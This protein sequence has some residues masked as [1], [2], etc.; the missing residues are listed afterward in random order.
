M[1]GYQL[2]GK[3]DLHTLLRDSRVLMGGF[4]MIGAILLIEI[5]RPVAPYHIQIALVKLLFILKFGSQLCASK[6]RFERKWNLTTII[7][8]VGLKNQERRSTQ[9]KHYLRRSNLRSGG[10]A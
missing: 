5:F 10:G 9:V 8:P 3:Q 6:Q 2:S 7:Y 1:W 4:C